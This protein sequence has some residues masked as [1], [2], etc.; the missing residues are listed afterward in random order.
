MSFYFHIFTQKNSHLK[1][2]TVS[3]QLLLVCL[4]NKNR[5]SSLR[6][7]EADLSSK[8]EM[9]CWCARYDLAGNFYYW[10]WLC[11]A[12]CTFFRVVFRSAFFN[13]E[14]IFYKIALGYFLF[15]EA[16]ERISAVSSFKIFSR[17]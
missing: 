14:F 6:N 2:I 8:E 15:M 3:I 10:A 5:K 4:K 12:S 7:M 11:C 16:N 13:D 17:I 9:G 1:N